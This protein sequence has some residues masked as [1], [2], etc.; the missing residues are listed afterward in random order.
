MVKLQA[1]LIPSSHIHPNL[2]AAAICALSWEHCG[3]CTG[4]G[5]H[6]ADPGPLTTPCTRAQP[7]Y[8]MVPFS[9]PWRQ[10]L[11]SQAAGLWA[12]FTALPH[13]CSHQ[14]LI[15]WELPGPMHSGAW[16]RSGQGVMGGGQGEGARRRT[17]GEGGGEDR[18]EGASGRMTSFSQLSSNREGVSD[19]QGKEPKLR[20]LS[21]APWEQPPPHPG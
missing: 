2:Q 3:P 17:Q 21:P 10:L 13:G 15:G 14:L 8:Q 5:H 19:E 20:S 18:G 1:P 9:L 11:P 6:P 16:H 12:N 4:H 7:H